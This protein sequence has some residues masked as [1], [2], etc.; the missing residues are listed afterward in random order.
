MRKVNKHTRASIIH[1]KYIVCP[2]CNH[3]DKVYHFSWS[4]L[5]CS[6]CKKII[7]K[8]DWFIH[9]SYGY[10]KEAI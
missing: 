5:S 8:Y 9:K 1:G 7:N 4:G 3:S 10:I 2:E 6:N